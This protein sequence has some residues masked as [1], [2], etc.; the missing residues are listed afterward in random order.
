MIKYFTL[1][2]IKQ[3]VGRYQH[4]EEKGASTWEPPIPILLREVLYIV[5]SLLE[6]YYDID[7]SAKYTKIS[8]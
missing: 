1:S 3:K 5:W 6:L 8:K 7:F 4:D 2:F